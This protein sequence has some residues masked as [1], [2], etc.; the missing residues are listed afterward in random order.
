MKSIIVGLLG[1]VLWSYEGVLF[2]QTKLDVL[3][4]NHNTPISA[5]ADRTFYR[6]STLRSRSL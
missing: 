4:C 2:A 1:S 6:T 5:R 3:A